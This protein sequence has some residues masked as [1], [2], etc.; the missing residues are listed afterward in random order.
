MIFF[1]EAM[2]R[3][4]VPEFVRHYHGDHNHRGRTTG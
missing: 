1:G 4:S 3:P 2:M